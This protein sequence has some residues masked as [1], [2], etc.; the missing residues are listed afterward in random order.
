M[1]LLPYSYRNLAG[2]GLRDV[3]DFRG[4]DLGMIRAEGM[5][6]A[7]VSCFSGVLGFR[8]LGDTVDVGRLH[9]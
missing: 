9:N 3:S 8:Y 2:L 7:S 1:I 6:T 4:L 5:I